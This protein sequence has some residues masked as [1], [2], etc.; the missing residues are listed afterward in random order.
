M[1]IFFGSVGGWGACYQWFL[2]HNLDLWVL[3]LPLV[4]VPLLLTKKKET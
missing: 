1:W 3:C 4:G 2:G